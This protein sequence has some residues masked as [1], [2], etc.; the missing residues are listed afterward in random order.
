MLSGPIFEIVPFSLAHL[1]FL[2]TVMH[3]G[4]LWIGFVWR[5]GVLGYALPAFLRRLAWVLVCSCVMPAVVS[6]R[7]S[8]VIMCDYGCSG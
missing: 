6:S 7:F 8:P 5:R 2:A 4:N 1:R 3:A